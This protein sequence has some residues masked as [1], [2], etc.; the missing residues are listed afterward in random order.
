MKKAQAASIAPFADDFLGDEA[1]SSTSIEEDKEYEVS[2]DLSSMLPDVSL[3]IP[4]P[5]AA[6]SSPEGFGGVRPHVPTAAIG[7]GHH[8]KALPHCSTHA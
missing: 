1:Q 7:S 6:E 3:S 4:L 2:S 5:E 8:K